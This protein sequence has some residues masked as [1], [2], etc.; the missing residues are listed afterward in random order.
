MIRSTLIEYCDYEDKNM[1][2]I[3]QYKGCDETP[4]VI[5]KKLRELIDKAEKEDTVFFY[6][7]GIPYFSM[8]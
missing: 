3:T 8:M 5:Y 1:E 7:S 2:V 4:E 6:F